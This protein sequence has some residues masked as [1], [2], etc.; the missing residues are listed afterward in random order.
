MVAESVN[1]RL[2]VRLPAPVGLNAIAAEQVP[3]AARLVPQVLLE[4]RKSAAL[5]PEIA[6]LLMVMED[7]SLFDNVADWDALVE[8]TKVLANVRPEGLAETLPP[9]AVPCPVNATFC[10]VLL[11]ESLKFSVALRAPV[12]VGPKM[13]FAVQFADAARE[14]PQVLLKIKKS[15]GFAPV[16]GDAADGD[17]G[18]SAIRKSDYLLGT[19]ATHWHRYPIQSGRRNGYLCNGSRTLHDAD[20]QCDLHKESARWQLKRFELN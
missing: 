5:V 3:D 12:A 13:I 2:A 7:V 10:G 18:R 9:A 14:V 8:P 20:S 4:I 6:T 15:P 11:A 17:R 19:L 1:L 16:E